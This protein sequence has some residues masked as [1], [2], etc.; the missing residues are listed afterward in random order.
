MEEENIN[1]RLQEHE[2]TMR[3]VSSLCVSVI[4]EITSSIVGSYRKGG[5]LVIFGNGGSAADAQH[6]AAE[7]AGRFKI[8]RKSLPA[9]ALTTNTSILTAIGN[10]YDYGAVFERQVEGIVTKEDVVIGISTS[11]NAENVIR[12]IKKARS[13]G[14][15]TIAFTGETGGKLK[16]EADILLLIPSTNT[17]RIQEAHIT[18]GHIICELVEKELFA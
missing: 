18:A 5:K 13:L 1:E 10:D 8:E 11:G 6:I 7:L 12:G 3:K 14:A 2:E 4:A 16:G 9:F 15:V 17:P